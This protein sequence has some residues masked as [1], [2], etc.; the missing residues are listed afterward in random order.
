LFD[1]YPAINYRFFQKVQEGKVRD[2]DKL[3]SLNEILSQIL[4]PES[5]RQTGDPS[6]RSIESFTR[7][8][9]ARVVSHGRTIPLPASQLF[10][11]ARACMGR[12]FS[13]ELAGVLLRYPSLGTLSSAD[14]AAL[15]F[16][17]HADV[18]L[19]GGERFALPD[20]FHSS[21]YWGSPPSMDPGSSGFEEEERRDWVDR[22]NPYISRQE[23]RGLKKEGA[24]GVRWA[25]EADYI[26]HGLACSRMMDSIG[27][28]M[29]KIRV[30]RSWGAVGD[31]I[32]WKATLAAM[33]RGEKAIYIKRRINKKLQSGMLNEYTPLVF[34]LS[35]DLDQNVASVVH[36]S[37]ISQRHIDL[38][39]RDF[40]YERYP[41]PDMVY[42]LF[43]TVEKTENLWGPH[44]Q[45]DSLT[46]VAFLYNRPLMG[47]DRYGAIS[48]RPARFQCRVPPMADPELREFPLSEKGI[49]WAIKYA[50]AVVI[51]AAY[52]GWMPSKRLLGF[53]R[54]KRVE[55][56]NRPLSTLPPD[57][58]K[59]L[60]HLY[61]I[62]TPLKKHHEREK[63]VR[64][65]LH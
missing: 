51:V 54:E 12:E 61:F 9:K 48:K 52:P 18:I 56:I 22:V 60:E 28:G 43:M 40:P 8:L 1:D 62:S 57:M 63:I 58:V 13:R 4:S 53:A 14:M 33:A 24:W 37:N 21:P 35:E 32:H 7:Y 31:G 47:L 41:P 39:D 38:G 17:I 45:R 3:D 11:S 55:I 42:T 50:Q 30:E 5:L 26:L 6:V 64:R 49:A 25:V 29:N 46:S 16:K 59:R 36:D 65:F 27:K 20:V 23:K 34:L 10:D 2:F 19:L 15:F 44:V